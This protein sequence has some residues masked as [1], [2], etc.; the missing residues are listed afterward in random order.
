[1]IFDMEGDKVGLAK[2]KAMNSSLVFGDAYVIELP[3]EIDGGEDDGV[4]KSGLDPVVIALIIIIV[5]CL[6][7]LVALGGVWMIVWFNKS[8]TPDLSKLSQEMVLFRL[9]NSPDQQHQ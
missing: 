6:L 9:P 2:H 3:R 4:S 7:V 5:A 1:M 8:P